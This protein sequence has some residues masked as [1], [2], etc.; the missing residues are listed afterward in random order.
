M[1][2][3]SPSVCLCGQSKLEKLL[4]FF[5]QQYWKINQVKMLCSPPSQGKHRPSSPILP[6]PAP[7]FLYGKGNHIQK[8]NLPHGLFLWHPTCLP[9]QKAESQ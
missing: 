8:S 6:Q 1:N 9:M 5:A 2:D 3:V 4:E 7:L